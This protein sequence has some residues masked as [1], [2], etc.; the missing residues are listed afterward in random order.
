MGCKVVSVFVTTMPDNI[1]QRAWDSTVF[2]RLHFLLLWLLRGI[3]ST[4]VQPA[5]LNRCCF[6]WEF[7]APCMR[8]TLFHFVLVEPSELLTSYYHRWSTYD[9]AFII[10]S[11]ETS[12][13]QGIII[14]FLSYPLRTATQVIR[15][16]LMWK[17]SVMVSD[18][19]FG[20]NKCK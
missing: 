10:L 9:N 11:L 5:F 14:H 3:S 4:Q 12:C 15:T 17:S 8:L 2:V 6:Y 1:F 20:W 13:G 7:R 18:S 19:C 16:T